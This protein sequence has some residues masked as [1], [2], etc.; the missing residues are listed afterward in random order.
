[1]REGGLPRLHPQAHLQHAQ[2][3]PEGQLRHAHPIIL[4]VSHKNAYCLTSIGQRE[5]V[6]YLKILESQKALYKL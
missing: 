3:H 4:Q 1:M 5:K 2:G 6:Y